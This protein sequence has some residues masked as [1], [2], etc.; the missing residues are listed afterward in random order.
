M[1]DPL[2][3]V[4]RYRSDPSIVNTGG[5]LP[6]DDGSGPL[7]FLHHNMLR[8]SINMNDAGEITASETPG[9]GNV[10]AIT[11]EDYAKPTCEGQGSVQTWR[12][13]DETNPDGTTKLELL[14]MWTTELNELANQTGRSPATANCSA[15]W[16]DEHDGVIAQGWYDQGVRFLDISNPRDIQPGRLLHDHGHVLGRVLRAVGPVDRLRARHDVG[17]RRAQ[18]LGRDRDRGAC[19]SP[20]P[21]CSR[22]GGSARPAHAGASPARSRGWSSS[23]GGGVIAAAVITSAKAASRISSARGSSGSGSWNTV[24]PAAIVRTL[25]VALVIAIT[26]DDR[27]ELQRAG[28]D[29]QA[30]EAQH[31]D[32]ERE[33]VHEHA[34]AEV[35]GLAAERLDRHVRAR[36]E[37]ARGARERRAALGAAREHDGGD[38]GAADGRVEREVV[39]VGVRA[40]D[41]ALER[42]GQERQ[43]GGGQRHADPFTAGDGVA[44]DAVGDD[45]DQ[46]E[47]AGDHR[48]HDGDRREAEREHVEAP[49]RGGHDAADRVDR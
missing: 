4:L 8:T 22:A 5:G 43:P 35:L 47:A 41:R 29:E 45:R 34:D 17:H 16:F 26:G 19:R 32:H 40:V 9:T 3:P 44:E 48:L 42:R 46:H 7:D 31:D 6:G 14:D 27:A 28:R 25:A 30:D 39:V 38:G 24:G 10:L 12:I 18:A 37:Q 15:H 36:P 2:N 23:A 33:R 20:R 13:T 1:T 21:T 11:E 49:G